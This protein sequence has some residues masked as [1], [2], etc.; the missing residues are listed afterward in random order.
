MIVFFEDQYGLCCRPAELVATIVPVFPKRYRVVTAEAVVGY[1][2][3]IKDYTQGDFCQVSSQEWLSVRHM[4]R[5]QFEDDRLWITLDSDEKV[6]V[7]RKWITRVRKFL[8]LDKYKFQPPELTRIFVREYPFEIACASADVLGKNFSNA[9][10]L[11][12]SLI[13]QTLEQIRNGQDKKYGSSPAGFFQQT[14][15]PVLERAG[16]LGEEPPGNGSE[17]LYKGILSR[18][19][20]DDL[21]SYRD[22][23][24][25]A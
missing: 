11:V 4:R 3:E 15:H 19:I 13:W 10:H 23:G 22:L 20:E 14:V 9:S 8:G 25:E 2:Y 18:M 12:V 7:T 1:C 5:L 24:F 16:L 21:F 17:E 6:K